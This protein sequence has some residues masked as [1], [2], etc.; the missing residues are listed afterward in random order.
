MCLS[1]I[2]KGITKRVVCAV[3]KT[4]LSNQQEL[5][6]VPGAEGVAGAYVNPH[7]CVFVL[8]EKIRIFS[9]VVFSMLIFNFVSLNLLL[10]LRRLITCIVAIV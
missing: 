8:S 6:T 10:F 5:F 7:G 2:E 9:C 1:S 4:V 3:C